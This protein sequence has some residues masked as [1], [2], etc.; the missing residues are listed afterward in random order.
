MSK[1]KINPN[2]QMPSKAKQEISEASIRKPA[3]D[4]NTIPGM[5][6]YLSALKEQNFDRQ[7]NQQLKNFQKFYVL[8]AYT[9]MHNLVSTQ[10]AEV[11]KTL[12]GIRQFYLVDVILTQFTEDALSPRISSDELF[13]YS[14]KNE[15]VQNILNQLKEDLNLDQI[16]YNITPD[17]CL[18]GEY[19]LSTVIEEENG[20]VDLIDDVDQGKV[21]SLYQNGN[22]EGYLVVD[23]LTNQVQKRELADYVKFSLGGQRIKVELDQ[24]VKALAARNPVIERYLKSVPRYLRVG[25][26][27]IYPFVSKLK[28]LELLEKLVPASKINKLSQGNLVSLPV[29]EGYDLEKGLEAARRIEGMVNKKVM[30]DPQLGEITVESILSTAGKTRVIP[31]FGDK[32]RLDKMDFK[33]DEP[34]DL[35][36]NSVEI[37]NIILDSVGVPSE[38]IYRTEGNSKNEVLKRN[39][40]YLRKLKVIQKALTEGLKS[41]AEIHLQN[42]DVD[43][44]PADIEVN[45]INTLIEIDNLDKLE[46]ADVTLSVLKNVKDFFVD[47][48]DEMSPFKDAVNMNKVNKFMEANL[49]TIGLA[50]ALNTKEEGGPDLDAPNEIETEGDYTEPSELGTEEPADDYVNT[51]EPLQPE[52]SRIIET[53]KPRSKRG[54]KK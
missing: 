48:T 7:N 41:I 33:S 40:K 17:L 4:L 44:D 25:K 37:R 2:I 51:D 39:A 34:D 35:F 52:E 47:M 36:S 28:E 20:L 21:I 32:G 43:Y 30:V 11:L 13:S 16:I 27:L 50:D 3:I 8:T 29:P 9:Q 14:S 1:V 23:D 31:T 22:V 19:T 15:N 42:C 12:A 5:D 6:E 54:K 18:N 53:K 10:M 24:T 46:H 45:F 26:S 38:L 49:R